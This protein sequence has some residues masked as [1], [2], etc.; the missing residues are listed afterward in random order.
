MLSFPLLFHRLVENVEPFPYRL[1]VGGKRLLAGKADQVPPR[2][3]EAA[4]LP[5]LFVI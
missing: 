2:Q 3:G 5:Q 4:G 1:P